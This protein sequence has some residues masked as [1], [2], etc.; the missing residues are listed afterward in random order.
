MITIQFFTDNA[1]FQENPNEIEVILYT[2][3]FKIKKSQA[4]DSGTIRD[5]NGNSIGT[6]I[7]S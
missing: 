1:A 2:L 6:W 4:G 7:R 3:A 5:S